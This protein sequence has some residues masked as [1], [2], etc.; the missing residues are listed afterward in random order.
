M[1]RHKIVHSTD[2][3]TILI[4]G[5]R[6]NPEPQSAIIRFPGGNVEVSRTT[7]GDYWAHVVVEK[8]DDEGEPQ[9]FELA[10]T[11]VDYEREFAKTHGIPDIADADHIQHIAVRFHR[12]G[13]K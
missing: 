9:K 2:A 1:S 6:G 7:D 11:R 8:F 3:T 10:A 5:Y 13:K 4:E 12:I